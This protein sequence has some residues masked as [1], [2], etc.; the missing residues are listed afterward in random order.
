[1]ELNAL[2]QN[3]QNLPSV[4][5]VVHELIASFNKDAVS[6]DEILGHVRADQVLCA[7]LLRA[8]NSAQFGLPRKVSS[9]DDAVMLL[10][11]NNLRT[12]IIGCGLAGSAR[13]VQGLD[14]AGFWRYSAHCAGAS[15]WI[16]NAS[17]DNSAVAFTVGMMHAIGQLVMHTAMPEAMEALSAEKPCNDP[18]RAEAERERF[19]YD[20]HRVS[21]ELA[22]RWH[23]PEDFVVAVRDAEVPPAT[24]RMAC[25]L[26][27]A[28]WSSRPA[29]Q[30]YATAERSRRLPRVAL[31]PLKL[32]ED[33]ILKEMPPVS[34]LAEGLV[35]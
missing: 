3:P 21:A 33:V 25:V 12:I 23:F 28:I 26:H 13:P 15:R 2:F 31:T 17:S 11:F 20:F 18:S 32:A 8:A 6:I 29:T 1:M 9:I 24:N 27:L 4:P 5:E 30:K 35:G 22:I 34:E 10:G 16:A 19:G 14:L 7:K